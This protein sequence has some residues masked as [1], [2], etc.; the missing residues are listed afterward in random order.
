MK[1][2]CKSILGLPY[3][4]KLKLLTGENGIN[5]SIEWVHY[6]EEPKYVEWLKGG[7]LIIITGAVIQNNNKALV[8][9]INQLYDKNVSG[10]VIN[11]SFF[12]E[13]VTNEVIKL[14]N[15]LELPIFEMPAE[16]RIVDIS[17]SICS[18]IF[19]RRNAKNELEKLLM[20]LIYG[21]KITEKMISKL[22]KY[23]YQK[24]VTYH[25]IVIYCKEKIEEQ[26]EKSDNTIQ[27]YDEEYLDE[28][29]NIVGELI[30][31]FFDSKGKKIL[32]TIDEERIIIM[33]PT[34][35]NK[36]ITLEL[37]EMKQYLKDKVKFENIY[38]GVGSEWNNIE[39]FKY[40]MN[41]AL[42]AI[43]MGNGTSNYEF[44]FDY[45]KLTTVRLINEV[46]DKSIIRSIINQILG[47]LFKIDRDEKQELYDT[48]SAYLL[49]NCNAKEAAIH[50][51]IHS[52][53]MRYRLKKIQNIL[54]CDLNNY[55]DLFEIQLAI[56]LKEYLDFID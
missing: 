39:D 36:E 4:N 9:I 12:I 1:V 34:C 37:N 35:N 14:G 29:F 50:L 32:Y 31:E 5:N 19:Q 23:N 45:N 33:L 42:D 48:L 8:N 18:A 47:N 46:Q 30:E 44:I 55:D 13:S 49:K 43:K 7:E 25:S 2:T 3:A 6:L 21:R 28:F 51:H 53:T 20:D 40:S 16:V 41:C 27:F 15:F 11:L 17:Q 38:I 52:N 54:K 10:V 22:V 56:K 26:K 24:N